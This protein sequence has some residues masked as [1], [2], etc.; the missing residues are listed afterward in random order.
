MAGKFSEAGAST[1]SNC[2]AGTYSEAGASTCSN[3]EAGKYDGGGGVQ[4][5]ATVA[6][7]GSCACPSPAAALSG[8]I[9]DGSGSYSNGADCSWVISSVGSSISISFSQFETESSS[10]RVVIYSCSSS[11][12]ATSCESNSELASLSGRSISSSRSWTSTTGYMRVW[13]TSDSSGTYAGFVGSWASVPNRAIC[14]KCPKGKYS[15]RGS[16][17]CTNCPQGWTTGGEGQTEC[18]SMTPM[19]YAVV[20]VGSVGGFFVGLCTFLLACCVDDEQHL[21][22]MSIIGLGC[23]CVT[24]LVVIPMVCVIFVPGGSR[25]EFPI[26]EPPAPAGKYCKRGSG[27]ARQLLDCPAGYTCKGGSSMPVPI[28][29]TADG[30]CKAKV[31]YYCFSAHTLP[32]GIVCPRGFTCAGGNA[33]AEECR[34]GWTTDGEGQT[35][36]RSMTPLLLAVVVVGSV[37]GFFLCLALGLS[38][39]A[40]NESC[41]FGGVC[42]FFISLLV[43]ISMVCVIFVSGGSKG[44]FPICESKAGMYCPPDH[45]REVECPMG[46]V[47]R[48]NGTMEACNAP[49]G[50]Y[51]GQGSGKA[52]ELLDSFQEKTPSP[53]P[54][55]GNTASQQ[56]EHGPRAPDAA[57]DGGGVSL[58]EVL[59]PI[60]LVVFIGL[61]YYVWRHIE[62]ERQRT[63]RLP[64]TAEDN[65]DALSDAD[66]TRIFQIDIVASSTPVGL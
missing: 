47:C 24:L 6:C 41:F 39:I 40:D 45:S 43:V 35:E 58:S 13:F 56:E 25:E 1:C 27:E 57:S 37:G 26:C 33:T 54:S 36:C 20:V 7:S 49:A 5:T 42:C 48:G 28:H 59:V 64:T 62:R 17:A 12:S 2:V 4:A 19:L 52:T 30:G 65:D 15:G 21:N 38:V 50:K 8:S 9:T 11:D 51:C 66:I 61:V 53:P 31:G 23:C 10:D 16:T 18:R 46:H 29:Q 34:L 63:Q 3:C 14:S 22:C 55:P 32:D 44:E 60:L